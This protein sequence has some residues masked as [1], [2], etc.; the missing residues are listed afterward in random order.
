VV[1]ILYAVAFIGGIVAAPIAPHGQLWFLIA[2]F[3]ALGL[4]I[5]ARKHAGSK[6]ILLLSLVLLG[7]W[8]AQ[9]AAPQVTPSNVAF[10]NGQTVELIGV[11]SEPP[12]I[13]DS[14]INYTLNAQSLVIGGHSKRVS[15]LVSLHTA[16]GQQYDMG[17]IIEIQGRLQKP[18]NFGGVYRGILARRGILSE[19]SFPSVELEG[20]ASTGILGIAASVS[21][22]VR[23]RLQTALPEP[24]ATFLI[25]LLLGV[26]TAQL[27]ALAPVL[28]RTGLIHLIA[29]SGLKIGIVAGTI[30]SLLRHT[31][32]RTITLLASGTVL[33]SY[34]LISGATVAGARSSI[35]WLLIFVASYLG[36]PTDS[37]VSLAATVAVML[38]INPQLLGDTGFQF[39]AFGTAGIILFSPTIGH[40]LQTIRIPSVIADGAA[41]TMAASI[42]VVPVQ[43]ASFHILSPMSVVANALVL[44]FVPFAMLV[45]SLCALFPT[46]LFVDSAYGIGHFMLEMARVLGRVPEGAVPMHN[47][48]SLA[49]ITYYLIVGCLALWCSRLR[50]PSFGDPVRLHGWRNAVNVVLVVSLSSLVVAKVAGPEPQG[51][52]VVGSGKGLLLQSSGAAILIDGGPRPS[53]LLDDLGGRLALANR[54]LDAV[55]VTDIRSPNIG[56][57]AELAS[58]IPVQTV[59]D[60]GAEYPSQT[61]ARWRMQLDHDKVRTLAMRQGVVVSAPGISVR[62]LAPDG[63]YSDLHDGAGILL[64]RVGSQRLLYVGPCSQTEQQDLPF[65]VHVH[66]STAISQVPLN[67]VLRR[68]FGVKLVLRVHRG[69]RIAQ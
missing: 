11:I 60:P 14:G 51:I 26:R 49:S 61:Y 8:R 28:I 5:A 22:W 67:G 1:L 69:E 30:H 12:D 45:A 38:G 4:S 42:A 25:A 58:R 40:G 15:G 27:G 43:V 29:V 41:V 44:P 3:G 64:I 54:R 37:L 17:D 6:V 66:V 18:P 7:C 32:E 50:F 63:V 19:I 46:P 21:S 9:Q 57:V 52:T 36:R 48:S 53:T 2:A 59:V 56:S 24:E 55:F 16:S 20:R 31:G 23:E 10:Y 35:M 65:R 39:T 47:L 34:W 62:V 68:G 33:F 13:R